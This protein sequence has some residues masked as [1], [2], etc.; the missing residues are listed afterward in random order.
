MS[1]SF[2]ELT[3]DVIA[4]QA[5]LRFITMSSERFIDE[6]KDYL[7][8]LNEFRYSLPRRLGAIDGS[9][10]IVKSEVSDL[11]KDYY[12]LLERVNALSDRLS[13]LSDKQRNFAEAYDK[14]S[15]WLNEV[16]RSAQKLLDEQVAAEPRAIQDQLD[17]V[18]ALSTEV[19]S[20]ARLIDNVRHTGRAFLSKPIGKRFFNKPHM[21]WNYIIDKN[22]IFIKTNLI[23]NDAILYLS[24]KF[25]RYLKKKCILTLMSQRS[26][27]R[28][29]FKKWSHHR[30]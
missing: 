21:K 3:N 11:S 5:D 29:F 15:R 30:R 14:A 13:G 22:S 4:H 24:I 19:N 6:V 17:R 8:S 26:R 20:Q 18:R 28:H 9:E 25:R 1:E 16:K 23:I 12:E 27:R 7:S 10:Y 2:R